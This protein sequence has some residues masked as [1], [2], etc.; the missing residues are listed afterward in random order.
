MDCWAIGGITKRSLRYGDLCGFLRIVK[1]L[2]MNGGRGITWGG[3]LGGHDG[4]GSKEVEMF[5]NRGCANYELASRSRADAIGHVD[6]VI[7]HACR[8]GRV[9][10]DCCD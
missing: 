4:C 2:D 7:G 10:R 5:G 3:Q 6:E 9:R 1:G 8:P